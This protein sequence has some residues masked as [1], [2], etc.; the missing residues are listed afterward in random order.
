ME[1]Y[2]SI[3]NKI[4]HVLIWK[5]LRCT[6]KLKNLKIKLRR[7]KRQKLPDMIPFF[8]KKGETYVIITY[9][10]RK[11]LKGFII[12]YKQLLSLRHQA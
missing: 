10:Q 7:R 9:V 8:L 1:H 6:I 4:F 5:K 3:K 12:S 2:E 11:F